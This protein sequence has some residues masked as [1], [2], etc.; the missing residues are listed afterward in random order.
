MVSLV[1]YLETAV[2]L[3]DVEK[4]SILVSELA[5]ST[6]LLSSLYLNSVARHVGSGLAL[7]DNPSEARSNYEEAIRVSA[8]VGFRPEV[9]L[10]RLQ[11][12]ELLLD[13]HPDERDAAIEHL[14]FAIA[15]FQAMKMQPSLE[16]A[17]RHRGLLKA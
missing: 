8:R 11:L 14:D 13:H 5:D 16:R 15:E 6:G 12:A 4:V 10:A 1:Q 3:R 9:A 7:L 2:I 17:L